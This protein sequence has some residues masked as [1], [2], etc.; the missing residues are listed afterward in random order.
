MRRRAAGIARDSL[1]HASRTNKAIHRR[2]Q[3]RIMPS[4]V[5]S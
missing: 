5:Q 3:I 2:I 4:L 1:V